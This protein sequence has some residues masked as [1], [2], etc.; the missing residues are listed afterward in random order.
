[1]KAS[2]LLLPETSVG[3]AFFHE[4][5]EV[6]LDPFGAWTTCFAVSRCNSNM[7][8]RKVDERKCF[9]EGSSKHSFIEGVSGKNEAGEM[10]VSNSDTN[11]RPTC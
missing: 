6:L 4:C 3:V 9:L 7:L 11:S 8:L 10:K 1:M 2:C 5:A